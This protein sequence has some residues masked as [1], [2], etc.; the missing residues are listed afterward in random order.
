[1]KTI[2]SAL[3]AAIVEGNICSI[4]TIVA[5]DGTIR[6]F[7][8]HDKELVVD[9]KTYIPSAGVTRFKTKITN[10][11][12]VSS[13]EMAATVLDMPHQEMVDGKWDNAQIESALVAWA[14]PSAGKLINFKG[15]IG[16]IQFTDEGFRADVQNYLRD[17]GRNFGHSV[18]ANCRHVLFSQRTPGAISYCGVNRASYFSP[19]TVT[20]ILGQ[21][22]KVVISTTGRPAEWASNGFAKF[23]SGSN[24]GLSFE[25]KK[26]LIE[27]GGETIA[28]Y[29]PT[30]AQIA[31][32]DTLEIS[33]GCD[34][35]V[36][37]CKSKFGNIVNFGGFPHL[38]VDV[39][40]RIET[41]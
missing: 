34:K 7:T 37:T 22:L 28:F 39:N 30:L 5:K 9:G 24:A 38:Q 40:S 2:S 1:M 23:T 32:G 31:I 27:N 26:H 19:A 6:C 33:A 20:Q 15:S 17:L 4:F 8:D 11:A 16:A 10:D 21:K 36:E 25:I 35:T 3:N 14:D 13:Q 29:I 41:S 18:T 12:E